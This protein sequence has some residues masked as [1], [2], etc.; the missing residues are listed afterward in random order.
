MGHVYLIEKFGNLKIGISGEGCIQSR[1]KQLKPEKVLAVS[2]P[3]DDYK[4]VEKAL[5]RQYKQFRLPQSEWFVN[6]T[7]AQIT[8]IVSQ[9]GE[10]VRVE[11]TIDRELRP[12]PVEPVDEDDEQA[13]IEC[14]SEE[15]RDILAVVLSS[16]W[17]KGF[18][19]EADDSADGPLTSKTTLVYI[20]FYHPHIENHWAT[21]SLTVYDLYEAI[22][23]LKHPGEVAYS[24]MDANGD[25]VEDDALEAG[26]M[27]EWLDGFCKPGLKHCWKPEEVIRKEMYEAKLSQAAG[28]EPSSISIPFMEQVLRFDGKQLPNPWSS[29]L[30]P[31]KTR[32]S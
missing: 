31:F 9:L 25:I 22:S 5:H 27:L 15:L 12:Q 7:P 2:A 32:A 6:L 1:L 20:D 14:W 28:V 8:E 23:D 26:P 4:Q 3:R 30:P 10:L 24:L 13:M 17:I 21:M 18:D 11:P 29:S 19:I 16:P